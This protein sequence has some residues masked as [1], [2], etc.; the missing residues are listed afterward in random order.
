MFRKL[1]SCYLVP[2]FMAN[3]WGD[4]E[5][6]ESLYIFWLQITASGDC[7]HEI[8]RCLL[9]G[10][11]AMNNL[12]ITLKSRDITLPTKVCLVK[13][14]VFS[15]SHVWMWEL[16]YKE[17]LASKNLCFWTVV[18]EKLLRVLWTAR[19]SKQSILKRNQ[20]WIYFGR[21]NV[22]AETPIVCPPDAKNWLI[23][24]DPDARK[25][26]RW[27]EK[28]MTEGEM[29]GWHHWLDGHEFE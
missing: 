20:S 21:T 24:K 2:S 29:V 28:G 18:L 3:R 7:S 15:S 11:K 4:S 1:R 17:S 25:D 26:W 8:K 19:R 12:D 14:M 16:D 23:G 5:N 9:L 27:E 13:A 10:R 6:N 22:E